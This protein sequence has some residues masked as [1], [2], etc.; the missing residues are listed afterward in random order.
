MELQR[1]HTNK[2]FIMRYEFFIACELNF[3]SYENI[4]N[5]CRYTRHRTCTAQEPQTIAL[6]V[7]AWNFLNF[8][9]SFFIIKIELFIFTSTAMLICGLITVN[10]LL[11]KSISILSITNFLKA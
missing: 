1:K 2:F 5:V 4:T 10:M 8:A 6:K 7:F 3:I 11:S 9:E